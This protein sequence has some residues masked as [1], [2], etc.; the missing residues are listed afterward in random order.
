LRGAPHHRG[1]ESDVSVAASSVT[2]GR[3]WQG[4]D[5]VHNGL[6]ALSI[7]VTVVAFGI[8]VRRGELQMLPIAVIGFVLGPAIIV[9]FFKGGERRYLLTLFFTAFAIRLIAAV[10]AHP[11]LVTV[12]TDKSGNKTG[13]V[14]FLFEDD[15]AYH[16]VA[17]SLLEY[18]TGKEGAVEK[19]EEY[20]LRLYTY[21]VAWL[22]MYVRWV[23]PGDLLELSKPAAGAIAV[24]APK[25]MNCFIGAVTV[26]PM[27]ALGRELGGNNAGRLVALGSAFWPSMVLWSVLNLKDAMVVALIATIMF[28]ALRFARKPGL[29]VLVGLLVAFA[30]ME[31]LR[32]YVF[33]AFGWLVPIAFFLINRAPWRRRLATGVALWAAILVIML[34]M[35]QG[36]QWLGLR[37]LTDKR[38]EALYGSAEFGAR[39]AESGIELGGRLNRFEGGWAIQMRNIP[40]VMPYVLWAPF[41]WA[42]TRFR[43]LAVLPEAIGWYA[44]QILTIV[45]LVVYGRTRWREFFLPVVYAGGLVFV[46]S[47]IE[48]NIGT[49]YRHRIMLF[50]AAF[51][52]A[53]VGALW[54]WSWWRTR[55]VAAETELNPTVPRPAVASGS[56]RG[57]LT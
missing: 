54:V 47:I 18:W 38:V 45:T 40:I 10:V 15:R 39:N 52:L 44:V 57:E 22:Y 28:C 36:N 51:P 21:M 48:S 34:G 50:P 49:I 26:A 6:R 17:Y 11:Y 4:L 1:Q 42:G 53:A 55:G 24:M 20:L 32:L 7:L 33:Y 3:R 19:S 5:L 25:L 56:L 8:L 46:F 16:K 2:S 13:W 14:G 31:N 43:D 30:M 23:T 29:V 12:T 35:N 41:P 27:Y 9:L 37:Y